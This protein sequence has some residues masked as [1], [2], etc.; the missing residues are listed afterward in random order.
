G[1][2]R[3]SVLVAAP[4]YHVAGLTAVLAASFAGRRIVLMR[5]FDAE[6]WLRLVEQERITHA[7][8]VPTMMKRALDHP[9]FATADLSSLQVLS[10]GA[11]P[12]PLSLIRRAVA[13]FPPAVQFINAFGQTET[14]STVTMLGPEDHRLEGSPYEAE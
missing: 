8:L 4:L 11:A 10:Y 1:S 5:Q 6:E 13:A 12:M 7:F 2:D 9:G 3:G 14:T